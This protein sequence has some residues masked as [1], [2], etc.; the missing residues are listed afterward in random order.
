MCGKG[1]PHAL[2]RSAT[3]SMI[4]RD[5]MKC[6]AEEN[7]EKCTCEAE[8]CERRG[9]CCECLRAHLSRRSLPTCMRELDW[10]EAKP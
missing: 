6:R 5:G 2:P 4:W 9:V 1:L 10:I 3:L 7:K 8:D